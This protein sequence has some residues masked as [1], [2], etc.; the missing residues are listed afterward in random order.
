VDADIFFQV[1]AVSF[2]HEIERIRPA[3]ERCGEAST[4][5]KARERQLIGRMNGVAP[6]APVT[7]PA[8]E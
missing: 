2:I 6:A 8:D 7:T 3:S 1:R 5:K 4:A